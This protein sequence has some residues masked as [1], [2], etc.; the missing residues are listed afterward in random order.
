V[1]AKAEPPR[2]AGIRLAG[3]AILAGA[4]AFALYLPVGGSAFLDFDDNLYVTENAAVLRG[5]DGV[6]ARA[7]FTRPVAGNWHPVTMLSHALDVEWFGLDAGKHHLVNA[8]LHGANAAL[9]A[10]L[11]GAITGAGAPSF[12]AALLFALH[13]QRVESVAWISERKDLLAAMFAL[14]ATWSYVAQ[15][16]RPRPGGG[17]RTFLLLALSLMSKPMAVTLPCVFLLLDAWPLGRF[18]RGE[19]GRRLV[20]KW[21]YFALSAAFCAVTLAAQ[22][23]AGAVR[24]TEV[25]TIGLRLQTAAVAYAAYLGK[26]VRPTGLTLYPHPGAWPSAAVAGSVALL[27]GITWACAAVARTRPWWIVGWLW[28]LGMLVP[29]IGLVKAGDQWMADR[30]TYLPLLGPLLAVAWEAWL[31]VRGKRVAVV[32]CAVALAGVAVA[33]AAAARKQM[34]V[35]AT[36]ESLSAHVLATGGENWAMRTNLA[37]ARARAGRW[38]EALPMFEALAARYPSDAESQANAGF[39]HLSLGRMD[40]ASAYT[41][42]ALALEGHHEKAGMNLGAIRERQGRPADALGAYRRVA[43]RHPENAA[44]LFHLARLYAE[45]PAWATRDGF[46]PRAAVV[47]ALELTPQVDAGTLDLAAAVHAACGD[48]P[49]ARRLWGRAAVQARAA[50]DAALAEALARRAAEAP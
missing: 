35:W 7:A 43:E 38:E 17:A 22:D 26:A 20:E 48:G 31:Q 27:A 8:A 5:L 50:G 10:G 21:P 36:S 18:R 30:Y 32:A 33:C 12:A 4:I 29:V 1:A 11:F 23:S 15:A 14:L 40:E 45:R 44:A 9:V 16:L 3:L 25:H 37:I 28:Y 42:R 39:A 41:E 6:S 34:A 49:G 19:M 2:G 47:R 24:G 46:D 13:P